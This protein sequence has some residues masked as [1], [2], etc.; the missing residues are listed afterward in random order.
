[1]KLFRTE[2]LSARQVQWLGEVVLIRPLPLKAAAAGSMLMAAAVIAFLAFG[3]YTP[4]TTVSGMLLPEAGLVQVFA[5]QSGIVVSKNVSEG[6]PV[7]QGDVLFVLSGE[8]RSSTQGDVQAGIGQQIEQRNRSLQTQKDQIKALR[9]AEDKS[10][11][12][13]IELLQAEL[14]K[15]DDQWQGQSRRVGLAEDTLMR[16]RD[17]LQQAFVSKEQLQQREA[18]LL[19]QRNRL[20][21]IERDRIVI[22]RDLTDAQANLRSLSLRSQTQLAP[23]DRELSLTVQERSENEVKRNLVITAPESGIATA[24]A[25]E[26]GQTVDT[27]KSLMSIVP[28]NSPLQAVLYAPSRAVGFIRPGSPVRLRYQA[29][30]FEKFGHGLG[31]VLSVSKTTL[32]A[33]DVNGPVNGP[34]NGPTYRITVRL[35]SQ[36]ISAYGKAQALQPGMAVEADI[37]QESRRLYEWVLSPVLS[38]TERL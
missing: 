27:R 32:Q 1:M 19:D 9:D 7:R 14:S 23:L 30:P 3:T 17:L 36:T 29:Y 15:L 18:D 13:R 28:S 25:A 10:L 5:Q 37:L 38:V 2:A 4:N 21:V 11:R 22:N 8:R 12:R 26:L 20:Q 31:V 6:R 35:S 16:T 34:A 24:D 33:G